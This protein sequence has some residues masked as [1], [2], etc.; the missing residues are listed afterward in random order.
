M[1]WK[2]L[3][4]CP[5][6]AV[7]LHIVPFLRLTGDLKSLLGEIFQLLLS[8]YR[9]SGVSHCLGLVFCPQGQN[10]GH[11]TEIYEYE[12]GKNFVVVVTFLLSI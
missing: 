2:P 9:K 1:I 11:M 10:V 7:Y 8:L 3:Y 12:H 5:T 4:T 6:L